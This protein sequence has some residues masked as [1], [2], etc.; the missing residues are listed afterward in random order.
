[1][2]FNVGMEEFGYLPRIFIHIT[3]Y[4]SLAIFFVSTERR[5]FNGDARKAK[6]ILTSYSQKQRRTATVVDQTTSF[7]FFTE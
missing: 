5:D 4:Y 2:H 7:E 3:E 1:M 6:P